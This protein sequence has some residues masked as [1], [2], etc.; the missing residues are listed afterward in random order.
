M[1]VSEQ[2]RPLRAELKRARETHGERSTPAREAFENLFRTAAA[3][4]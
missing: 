1:T 2:L 3:R 4:P